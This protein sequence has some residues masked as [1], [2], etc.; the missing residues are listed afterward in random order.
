MSQRRTGQR[1]I[2]LLAVFDDLHLFATHDL[3]TLQADQHVRHADVRENLVVHAPWTCR[4]FV[5]RLQVTVEPVGAAYASDQGQIRWC[6]TKPGLGVCRL[7]ADVHVIAN[8]GASEHQ[9]LQHHFVRNA[10]I[11]G[12]PLV[13]LELGTVATHAIVGKG[14][15]AILQRSVVGNVDVDLFQ[16][17]TTVFSG[18]GQNRQSSKNQSKK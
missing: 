9:F 16:L 18:E 10:Q 15:C 11:I 3:T 2:L 4:I 13:T 8:L 12:H 7:H 6:G 14:T 5:E 1:I 17:R